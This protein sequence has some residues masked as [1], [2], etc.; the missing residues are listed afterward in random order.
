MAARNL[1]KGDAAIRAI[2]PATTETRLSDGA[3]LF[4][5]LF[6]KGGSHG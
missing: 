5:R 1:I 2:R 3:G 6:V 4:L